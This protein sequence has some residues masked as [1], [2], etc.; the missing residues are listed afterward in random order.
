LPP[1]RSNLL[2]TSLTQFA[3]GGNL[4]DADKK[5][6][7]FELYNPAVQCPPGRELKQ[8][9][10]W[11]DPTVGER[12]W[13]RCCCGPPCP[14]QAPGP[15][16]RPAASAAGRAGRAHAAAHAQLTRRQPCLPL[17]QGDG[18]KIMCGVSTLQPG[19]LIYSLGSNGDVSFEQDILKNTPC[20]VG[21]ELGLSIQ[22]R[23]HRPAAAAGRPARI[24][25][26][27]SVAQPPG[28]CAPSS[29]HAAATL[30]APA[31]P[32]RCT[33]STAQ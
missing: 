15:M 29:S 30:R 4:L 12:R 18:A 7:R 17:S 11:Q 8:Y 24:S 9:G 22:G 33:P 20:E 25:Q 23:G 10:G 3:R 14:L 19:C 31:H 2:E 16:R 5:Y 28:T 1:P 6:S 32:R 26:R 27:E 13:L 21:L